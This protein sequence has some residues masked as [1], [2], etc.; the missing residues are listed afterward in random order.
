MKQEV[1][2]LARNERYIFWIIT[3]SLQQFKH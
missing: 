3:Y 2:I 1:F